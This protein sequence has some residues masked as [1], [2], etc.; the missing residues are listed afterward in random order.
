[1]FT[2]GEEGYV[3]AFERPKGKYV[4]SLRPKGASTTAHD[5][6][7]FVAAGGRLYYTDMSLRLY[8]LEKDARAGSSPARAPGRTQRT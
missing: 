1:M 8:A 7:R 4:W 3:L 5:G 6:N 2:G